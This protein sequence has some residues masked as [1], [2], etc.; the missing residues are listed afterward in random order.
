MLRFAP[1]PTGDMT[2]AKLRVAIFNYIVSKQKNED[3]LIRIDDTNKD[4]NIEGKDKEILEL[5]NLFSIDS[6]QISYQSENLKY[7]QR[8]A[9]QLLTS[10]KAF[11]CFCS[12]EKLDELKEEAKKSQKPYK[13]DGFCGT[14]SEETA[15]NCNAPFTLRLR[16]AKDNIKFTDLLKGDFDYK[17]S[18]LDSFFILNHDKN[19][20][21]NFA[22]AIDDMLFNISTVIR[23]ENQLDNTPKQIHIRESLNYDKKI[24]Y[25]HIP[26]ILNAKTNK[27]DE[28]SVKSLI[29]AGFLPSSIA[30][31]L[32]LLGFSAPEEIFTLEDAIKWFDI[33]KISKSEVSFDIEKLKL[34]NIKHLEEMDDLRLSKLLGFADADIGKLA[35][36]YLEETSTL[37]ELKIKIDIIFALKTPI[38]DFKEELKTLEKC[39]KSAPFY[40]NFD[41]L[42]KYIIN[43]TNLNEKSLEEPLRYILTGTLSGPDISKI[44]ALIKNYLGEIIK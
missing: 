40:A 26:G 12:D 43:E 25:I 19:P 34:I 18:D 44:Y 27:R 33:T 9:M 39:I 15:F 38:N 42:K 36:L 7:H 8:M 1:S 22:C 16:L 21:A 6:S 14:I 32:V 30:N 17:A 41:D 13:Y 24:D 20:N 3:L 11:S 29:D 2:I 5:L 31:Y 10:K 37:K 23:D 4:D 35:K 28:T